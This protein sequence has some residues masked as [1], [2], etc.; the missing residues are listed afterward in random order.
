MPPD[1]EL[2]KE[3]SRGEGHVSPT[4]YRLVD[5]DPASVAVASAD[6]IGCMYGCVFV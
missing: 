1:T 3:P 4:G 6:L 5:L 2:L